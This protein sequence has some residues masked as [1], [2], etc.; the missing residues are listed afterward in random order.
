MNAVE[1]FTPFFSEAIANHILRVHKLGTPLTVMET[2]TGSLTNTKAIL[3]YYKSKFPNVYK[4]MH[5]YLLTDKLQLLSSLSLACT[6][7]LLPFLKNC[8]KKSRFCLLFSI[9]R[10]LTSRPIKTS[11]RFSPTLLS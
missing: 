11:A 5:Y 10:A 7:N 9:C 3:S 4:N 8:Q 6:S 1:L 2:S